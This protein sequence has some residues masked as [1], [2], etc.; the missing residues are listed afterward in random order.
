M[1]YIKIENRYM[2]IREIAEKY[3]M[4]RDLIAYRIGKGIR[5]LDK[6]IQPKYE[7]LRK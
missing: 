6:L 4:P 7:M 3:D 2:T 1:T 5:E